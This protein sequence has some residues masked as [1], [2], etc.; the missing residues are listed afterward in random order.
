MLQLLTREEYEI[1]DA[2]A[3]EIVGKIY[4][5][6]EPYSTKRESNA[7]VFSGTNYTSL[8]IPQIGMKID[9]T[10]KLSRN[11]PK[12]KI[13]FCALKSIMRK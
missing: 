11:P 3:R 4:D 6:L 13:N 10:Q 1:E 2:S 7:D 9:V 12:L 5:A 8:D